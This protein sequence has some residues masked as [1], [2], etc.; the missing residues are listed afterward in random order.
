MGGVIGAAL[1]LLPRYREDLIST[2]F[3]THEPVSQTVSALMFVGLCLYVWFGS[4]KK[5]RA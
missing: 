2:P 1:R 5:E 4:L 3:Y